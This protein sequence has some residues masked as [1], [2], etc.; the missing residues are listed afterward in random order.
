M[1][2][3]TGGAQLEDKKALAKEEMSPAK[4]EFLRWKLE[5]D[6][7]ERAYEDYHKRADV[8]IDRYRDQQR[9]EEETKSLEGKPRRYNALW[10]MAETI[11][12][13]VFGEVPRPYVS[14][15]HDDDDASSR[16]ASL[17]LQR[18]LKV[19]MS[20]DKVYDALEEASGDYVLIA[21]G[22]TWVTYKPYFAVRDSEV[23][24]YLGPGE[25]PP[26]DSYANVEDGEERPRYEKLQDEKGEYY[27][28]KYEA[29][30]TED[31]IIESVNTK[32]F[33]HGPANK[34][35][36]VPWIARRVPMLREELIE[37]FGKKVGKA[38]PL[39]LKST[40]SNR[41][42][43][44]NT[45]DFQGTFAR[46][47]IW[48]IWD[49]T[50]RRTIWLCPQYTEGLLD[51]RDDVLKLCDF[52]PTPKPMFG[53]MTTDTLEPV[54]D[55]KQW[56]DIAME[57]D[58]VSTRIAMLTTALQVV[59]V[60]SNEYGAE[61]EMLVKPSNVNKMIPVDNW[62]MFA[63]KGGLKGAVDFL[64]IDQIIIVLDKLYGIRRE[65]VQE[66]YE[67]TG[68]S[69]I[70]RGASDPRETAAAQKL[71][72]SFA[73]ARLKKR[74]AIVARHV[75]G[76]MRLIVEVISE[77]FSDDKILRLSSAE[78]IFKRDDGQFDEARWQA[79]LKIIRNE[80][81][82]QLKVQIDNED[83]AADY[84]GEQ[85][86]EAQ[87]M[88]TS[89]S[90]LMSGAVQ[91]LPIAPDFGKPLAK[92][93]TFAMRKFKVGR[94]MQAE[95]ARS[96]EKAL[97]N[98]QP[99]QQQGGGKEDDP[100]KWEIEKEKLQLNARE[101]DIKEREL[102][103]YA[104]EIG[105]KLQK[106]Q[107]ETQARNIDLGIKDYTAK[108]NVRLKEYDLT[109][110]AAAEH[111]DAMQSQAE[112]EHKQQVD[113]RAADREDYKTSQEDTRTQLEHERAQQQHEDGL[114][115]RE[116][117]RQDTENARQ[118][119]RADTIAQRDQE[120][121]DKETARSDELADRAEE[122][123]SRERQAKAKTASTRKKAPKAK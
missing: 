59:G 63:E 51:T 33:L 118:E 57:L 11:K 3:N 81:L 13:L 9:E 106:G 44:K 87:Q 46:A 28:E 10:S 8:I 32:D 77:L 20:G 98:V 86:E 34:W 112:L 23:K 29:K 68:I 114:L 60:Y 93:M 38:I 5:L 64:P 47:E 17:V 55:Y 31:I 19:I 89:L 7:A 120:R 101:L 41:V 122:R 115:E 49:R 105:G 37:R 67:V 12:P 96:L 4:R 26:E 30:L 79:A 116:M 107:S 90:Q 43:A 56:Q 45:D 80:P 108:N 18:V 123:K 99:P 53:T 52:F 2:E 54:P 78:Q 117:Q 113:T 121:A 72:G 119:T 25:E 109:I 35:S 70:V 92:F 103:I 76:L 66:L 58:D 62:A 75:N 61:I 95:M 74:Q 97:S 83:L 65:L 111:A 27:R 16:D 82:M 110:K 48:E 85:K 69:D 24:T 42:N 14:Q 88:L 102:G 1:I 71:K 73:S 84:M 104:Q 15:E 91:L 100:R 40:G 50:K 22:M 6:S 94:E 39:S 21:R 36:T